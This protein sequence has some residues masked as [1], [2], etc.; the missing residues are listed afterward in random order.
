VASGVL[1]SPCYKPMSAFQNYIF[2]TQKTSFGGQSGT[3]T[4]FL[5]IT[6]HLMFFVPCILIQL[7]NAK[8]PNGIFKLTL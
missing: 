5:P 1:Y 8:Q 6:T 7:C 3:G 2:K 4:G